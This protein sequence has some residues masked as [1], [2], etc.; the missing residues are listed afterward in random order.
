[1]TDADAALARPNDV[2]ATILH[3]DM[4]AFY[5][6]VE[7]LDHPELRGRPVI[8]GG[9]Q[10]RGVVASASYE[11]RAHGVRSAMPIGQAL[12]L[13]PN[14]V[15]MPVRMGRYRE[16]SARVMQ[17]FGEVTPFIEKLSIDEAFLDVAGAVRLFGPP[18]DIAEALRERVRSE[19]GLPCSIGVA[20]TKFVAKVAS[21]RAKP[22]GLLVVPVAD[23]LAF[24]H[25]LP[26]G[27][28]WGVGSVR[29]A[30]LASLGLHTIGDLAEL[31]LA[32]LEQRFGALGRHLF[33]LANGRDPRSVAVERSE[34]SVGHETT[35]LTDVSD[36]DELRRTLLALAGRTAERLRHHGLTARTVGLKLRFADFTTISRSR[37]LGEPTDVA[38]RL[39]EESASMLDDARAA[40]RR[41]V[42]LLGVRAEGLSG[43]ASALTL[44]SPDEGW[45]DTERAL[46][47]VTGRFGHGAVTPAALLPADGGAQSASSRRRERNR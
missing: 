19:T 44:W 7:V 22:D 38:R 13:S 30:E 15:V 17:L 36:A 40:D 5:A 8:V 43:E 2:G 32:T 35:F 14:A 28:L 3:A 10:G 21:A 9:D 46:D 27:A 37:T 42:R 12:R 34:K 45:R 47:Q 4:D 41:P 23:T 29:Q 16:L 1:M 6:S 11:A 31:P 18:A 26:V 25:P 20:G 24:L 33:E 39:Y